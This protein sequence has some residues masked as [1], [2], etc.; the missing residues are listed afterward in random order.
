M[1]PE[2]L[3]I[4]LQRN[5]KTTHSEAPTRYISVANWIF[6]T[7][8]Q[9]RWFVSPEITLCLVTAFYSPPLPTHKPACPSTKCTEIISLQKCHSCAEDS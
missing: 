5:M 3:K 1:V 4:K 7:G 8:W 6:V 2:F 9:R